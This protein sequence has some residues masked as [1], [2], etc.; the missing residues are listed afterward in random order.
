MASVWCNCDNCCGSD[1][2]KDRVKVDLSSLPAS[3]DKENISPQN[4][5]MDDVVG[6]KHEDKALNSMPETS[7]PEEKKKRRQ[8]YQHR[9]QS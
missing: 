3:L 2:I 7:V 9:S 4:A 5:S 8:R 6:Q 1:P